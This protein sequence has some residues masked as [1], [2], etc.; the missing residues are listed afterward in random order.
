[1]ELKRIVFVSPSNFVPVRNNA[2]TRAHNLLRGCNSWFAVGGDLIQRECW[3]KKGKKGKKESEGRGRLLSQMPIWKRKGMVFSVRNN[4]K[5]RAHNLLRGCNS[6][7]G[8]GGDLI[9]RKCWGKKG[10]K[11]K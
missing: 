10:K 1:M 6:W 4:A 3:G 7:F 2:K 5:T 9:Q 11:R 8:V